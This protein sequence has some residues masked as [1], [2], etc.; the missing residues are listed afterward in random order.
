MA[1]EL[2]AFNESKNC[3]SDYVIEIWKLYTDIHHLGW[4][5]IGAIFIFNDRKNCL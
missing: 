3:E 5:C 4:Y 1:K 2:S